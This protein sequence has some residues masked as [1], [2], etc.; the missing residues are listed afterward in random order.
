MAELA[1]L[2]QTMPALPVRV[3]ERKKDKS[4]APYRAYG[5]GFVPDTRMEYL[6][7]RAY[8]PMI[9]RNWDDKSKLATV[10]PGQWIDGIK[11]HCWFFTDGVMPDLPVHAPFE[12]FVRGHDVRGLFVTSYG[13]TWPDGLEI[14]NRCSTD[15]DLYNVMWGAKN[16]T[17]M[18]LRPNDTWL[19]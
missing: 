11:I 19:R 10:Q 8:R 12:L 15:D 18:V 17:T 1:P 6:F 5:Y 16:M 13:G 9:G 2:E 7:D 4:Y 3:V 14:G